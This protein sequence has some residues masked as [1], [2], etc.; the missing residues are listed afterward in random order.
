M[1][2]KDVMKLPYVVFVLSSYDAPYVDY[3]SG[4]KHNKKPKL[5]FGT[6]ISELPVDV[7]KQIR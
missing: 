7:Q 4:E 1:S 5:G 6:P 3:D 2:Y